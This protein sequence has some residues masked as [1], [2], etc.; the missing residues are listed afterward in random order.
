MRSR[1]AD[2]SMSTL[3]Y[4]AIAVFILV[5]IILISTG[6]L[7][8]L[9][10]QLRGTSDQLDFTKD[11][12]ETSC[13]EAK[14]AT[15]WTSTTFCTKTH[16]LTVNEEEQFLNC[17]EDPI[18]IMCKDTDVIGGKYTVKHV[19]VSGACEIASDLTKEE[20]DA[21]ESFGAETEFIEEE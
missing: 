10:E 11:T 21:L 7:G 4:A 12:C 1:K 16:K 9:W 17:W 8:D 6:T 19:G 14:A 15:S 3:V 20:A 18:G 13:I 2:I 5:M